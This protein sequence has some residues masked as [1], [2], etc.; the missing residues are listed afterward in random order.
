MNYWLKFF[1]VRSISLVFT[2]LQ[3][4]LSEG[5]GTILFVASIV[6]LLCQK[7]LLV[8]V[9][10]ILFTLPHKS[11]FIFVVNILAKDIIFVGEL[12]M[13]ELIIYIN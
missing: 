10:Y 12:A 1:A 13:S 7:R 2:V 5:F 11:L 6:F 4:Q 9:H 3:K 8:L